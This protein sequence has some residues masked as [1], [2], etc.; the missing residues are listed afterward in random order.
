MLSAY[1]NSLKIPE[2]RKRILFTFGIIAL[3]R[4]T[5]QIPVPGVD[6]NQLALLFDNMRQSAGGGLMNMFNIFS[7]GAMQ[8]FAVAA[9]GIMPYISASIIMQMMTPVIPQLEKLQREGETGRQKITQYTRYL[10]VI[11]CVIQGTMFAKTMANPS[12]LGVQTNVQPV[13]NPGMGFMVMTVII[14][15]GGTMFL[16]WLGEQITERGIG[17][18]ASLIITVN[19][20]ARLPSAIVGMIT[21]VRAGG[22]PG[23]GGQNFTIIHVLLLLAGF[24]AVCAA[25]V[26]IT[27]GHR[28]IPVRHARSRGGRGMGSGQTSYMP[29]RVNYSGVMPIIF[30]SAILMFPAM[31][32]QRIPAARELRLGRF[33]AYGSGW[34]MFFFAAAIIL[35]SFFW[36]A[37]QFNPI[38]I[39]DDL[40][41]RGGYVP[42]I[43]PGQPTAAFLDQTMTRITLAGATFLCCLAVLP[44]VLAQQFSIPPLVAQFFGGTSLLIMVGVMLDTM[45]QME[46]HLLSQHYDGFLKKGHLRSRRGM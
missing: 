12:M 20:V 6:P 38:N 39:A 32:L 3:V 46:G 7:G 31:I 41:K 14:L 19:I 40:Q 26:A 18:G 9:L 5:S 28:K 11:I 34:Y 15:T 43:R 33:F 4:V 36:V 25:T 2:L 35:F 29:L 16:M 27:Q 24:F 17:N 37:N 45:R 1:A 13:V 22:Q 42:G 44:M 8:K 10:T 21:L 30:G 23:A